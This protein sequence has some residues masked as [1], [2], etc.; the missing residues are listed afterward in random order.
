MSMRRVSILSVLSIVFATNLAF[1]GD[2]VKSRETTTI[3][4]ISPYGVY[5]APRLYGNNGKYLGNLSAN[6]Y[7][8]NSPSNVY[9]PYGSPYSP[10][11]VNNPYG[12][13][14]S[15]YTV[16]GAK[17]QYTFGGAKIFGGDGEFLGRLN[18]NRFD[19]Q[20]VSNPYGLYG[21]RF[22]PKSI[23]NPYG[24][25]GSPY[26]SL[27]ATNPYLTNPSDDD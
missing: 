5:G 15:R 20:S 12:E 7:N 18:S 3:K 14:G 23:N 22:S 24:I 13:Y 17:N 27:S 25:Y 6:R 9:G 16:D 2:S 26:S 21:S 4:P 8:L 1:A 10:Q 19:P 11:S